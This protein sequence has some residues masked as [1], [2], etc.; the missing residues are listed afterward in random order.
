LILVGEPLEVKQNPDPSNEEI[1]EL[2]IRY[3]SALQNLFEANKKEFGVSE[4]HHLK[5]I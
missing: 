5:F 4:F 1:N 3:V 2:H